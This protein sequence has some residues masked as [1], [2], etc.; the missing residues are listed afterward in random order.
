MLLDLLFPR[1]CVG[2]GKIGVYVCAQCLNRLAIVTEYICPECT[3]PSPF[4][5]THKK[6]LTGTSL[7]GLWTGFEY[8]GLIQKLVGEYKYSFVSDITQTLV[9]LSISLPSWQIMPQ[10]A[11]II[12]PVPLHKSR[13]RERGY[14][15]SALMA[16]GLAQY[17]DCYYT[18]K[19]VIRQRK[20][21]PQMQLDKHH[22]LNNLN[23]AFKYIGPRHG[24]KNLSV[25]LVDDVWTTGTT[26][27][28]TARQLKRA[29]AEQVWGWTL[30]R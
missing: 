27:R 28:Q 23:K 26:L 15:Q 4:G 21:V 24:L 17:L 11:W 19:L 16:K 8:K 30:A 13:L 12:T 22:R 25:L 2:C 3:K 20:T 10:H 6:C 1:T 5:T 29:G 18:D 7:T 9:E 14:N